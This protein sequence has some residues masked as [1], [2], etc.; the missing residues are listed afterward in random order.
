M[1]WTRFVGACVLTVA[2]AAFVAVRF[3]DWQVRRLEAQVDRL[4]QEKAELREF[5]TRICRSRRVAQVNILDQKTLGGEAYTSLRWQEISASGL[6]GEPLLR[7]VRGRQVYF[8]AL[9]LKFEPSLLHTADGDAGQSIALFRRIFGDQEAS[10]TSPEFDRR[11]IPPTSQPA[12]PRDDDIWKRFWH[13]VVDP[14][15]AAHY[16]IRV[17]QIEAPALPVRTGEVIE[18]T[19]DAIG[20]LNL[21]KLPPTP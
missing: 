20:G 3:G 9:V 21:R 4:E 17:A 14:A 16:G 18:V 15:L 2:A 13:F 10:A 7:S 8:E 5:A 1:R 6:V 12:R 19:L 11:S